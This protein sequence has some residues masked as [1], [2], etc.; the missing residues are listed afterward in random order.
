MRRASLF[1][2]AR[3]E[4]FPQLEDGV[5]LVRQFLDDLK[6][7]ARRLP[8]S[9][10]TP[11]AATLVTG[12]LAGPLLQGLAD[13]LNRVQ[14]LSVNVCVV[15]NTFFEGNISVAGLLTGGDIARA[16]N[17]MG[18]AT[19]QDVLV[20]SIMLRDPDRDVFLD[21]MTLPALE[22]AIGRRVRVIERTPT[23]AATAL[24]R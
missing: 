15:H 6:R 24:L 8:A 12:E 3:Y 20:P 9:L 13:T 23:A 22:R 17:N 14:G 2:A 18:A 11:R 1:P 16:I 21:D 5:G 7:L 4:G 19:G 10:P